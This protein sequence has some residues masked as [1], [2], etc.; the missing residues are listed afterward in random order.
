[1][2]KWIVAVLGLVSLQALALYLLGQPALCECGTVTLWANEIFS[3]ENSQQF[4]DWYTFSH[5][6]HGFLFYWLATLFFPRLPVGTRLFLAVGAEVSWEIFENT[7]MVIEH[8]RQ[9]ALAQ[10]YIG[11][12]I[13][14]S[15]MD[16]FSM[17]AGFIIAWRLPVWVTV[18]L[19]VGMEGFVLYMIRDSLALNI[20]GF[21]IQPEIISDWQQGG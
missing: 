5:I 12:S 1:M 21:F 19:A 18:L 2:Q 7:P 10:G 6:I 16:T 20:L 9:Q 14:N 11:D 13:L 17:L 8:Y 4:F 15:V 3:P